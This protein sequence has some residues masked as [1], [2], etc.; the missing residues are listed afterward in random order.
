MLTTN[1]L[2]Q[3]NILLEGAITYFKLERPLI[4]SLDIL[5]SKK[6]NPYFTNY[7]I[8]FCFKRILY[9]LL[10]K[11]TLS[12]GNQSFTHSKARSPRQRTK[13]TPGNSFYCVLTVLASIILGNT[14]HN[15][16]DRCTFIDSMQQLDSEFYWWKEFMQ[17]IT[18]ETRS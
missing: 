7:N 14:A 10:W 15:A 6:G 3:S 1:T 17:L 5:C 2:M 4:E 13:A 11:Y 16:S 8:S 9:S 12:I 18:R